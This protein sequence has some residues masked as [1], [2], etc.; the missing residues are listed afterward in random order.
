MSTYVETRLLVYTSKIFE[1]HL[2]KKGI[3][4]KDAGRPG[5][6]LKMSLST[7]VF[8]TFC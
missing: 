3:L 2:W 5:S 6:L 7:G 1:E 4:S 8:Q